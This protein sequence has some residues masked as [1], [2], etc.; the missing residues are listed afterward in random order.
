M[1]SYDK[2][3]KNNNKCS[4]ILNHRKGQPTVIPLIS[5]QHKKFCP[6]ELSN[7]NSFFQQQDNLI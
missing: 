3:K 7:I 5:I 6:K 1:F 4:L 2:N